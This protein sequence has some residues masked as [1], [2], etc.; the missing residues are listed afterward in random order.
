M[1]NP[2]DCETETKKTINDLD[3]RCIEGI[4]KFMSPNDLSS[5]SRTC[6]VYKDWT[7]RYFYRKPHFHRIHTTIE[8]GRP[9][10]RYSGYWTQIYEIRFRS[11]FRF[12]S[13][14]MDNSTSFE[15]FQFMKENCAKHLIHLTFRSEDGIMDVSR[16]DGS[17]I[18]DQLK[19]LQILQFKCMSSSGDIYDTFL[20]YCETLRAL[21]IDGLPI[22][23]Q[24]NTVWLCH[25]YSRLE[26]IVI[27]DGTIQLDLIEFPAFLR[28]NPQM[29][30]VVTDQ[31]SIIRNV[32]LTE[33][34]LDYAGFMFETKYDL[35]EM[36]D[37][38]ETCAKQEYVK[39][40]D[41]SVTEDLTYEI[42]RKIFNFQKIKSIRWMV[43]ED[44][45]VEDALR[46]LRPQSHIETLSL[47]YITREI[48]ASIP[49][50][51]KCFPSVR[52]LF[53]YVNPH[54]RAPFKSIFL[55]LIA[56]HGSLQDLYIG[57]IM[58]LRFLANDFIDAHNERSKN[59]HSSP[60]TVHLSMGNVEFHSIIPDGSLVKV[61][62][63]KPDN[64][65]HC[66]F[67]MYNFDAL[68][69]YLDPKLDFGLH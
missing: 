16:W 9:Q 35:L 29:R 33:T 55:P 36:W 27:V 40:I 2:D 54:T 61:R 42:L 17:I 69:N 53:I 6:S 4:L 28:N 25:N 39:S 47:T 59:N 62:I 46:D 56:Q 37:H 67:I 50:I 5:F 43:V 57:S 44:T 11:L 24:L 68:M 32:C 20:K 7:E 21:A 58:T 13:V 52:K 38:L 30:N 23:T 45:S 22:K 19:L 1:D 3:V 64:Y 26:T 63:Y 18:A 14:E 65:T 8:N 41:L 34:D 31:T 60:V 66:P 49:Q 51:L 48:E 15:I 12:L 10:F